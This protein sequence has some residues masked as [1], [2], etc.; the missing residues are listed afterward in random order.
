MIPNY[1]P[2]AHLD[3]R[4]EKYWTFDEIRAFYDFWRDFVI[5]QGGLINALRNF[6]VL[7]IPPNPE[8]TD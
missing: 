4:G 5:E 2:P 6:Y 1:V 8:E 3:D 7:K